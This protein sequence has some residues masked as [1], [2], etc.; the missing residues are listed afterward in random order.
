MLIDPNEEKRFAGLFEGARWRRNEVGGVALYQIDPGELAAFK[1]ATVEEMAT[2]YNLDRFA[3]ILH[4]ARLALDAGLAPEH[5]DAFELRSRGTISTVLAGRPVRPQLARHAAMAKFLDSRVFALLLGRL[6]RH[7]YIQ[8]RV[9]A[10]LGRA[11][12]V[13]LTTSGIWLSAWSGDRVA[14]GVVGDRQS[15]RDV[16]AKYGPGA[17]QVFYPYP[18]EYG[19]D[20]ATA[21]GQNL[22]V[23][24]FPRSALAALDQRDAAAARPRPLGAN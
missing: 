10:E 22:L 21:D 18:L 11:P 5:L 3:S 24:V 9:M 16:I 17:A 4:A 1:F 7:T 19:A 23:M 15:V 6:A 14:I 2:R 8:Y 12:A 20:N 13:G